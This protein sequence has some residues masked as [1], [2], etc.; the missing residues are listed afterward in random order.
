MTRH[1]DMAGS[2]S[3]PASVLMVDAQQPFDLRL[4]GW[5]KTVVGLSCQFL[6]VQPWHAP[7]RAGA[8]PD[9]FGTNVPT[10]RTQV[11][12]QRVGRCAMHRC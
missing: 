7:A 11:V 4:D 6:A 2:S 5:L 12:T 10:P 9:V 8:Q 3:F 1:N